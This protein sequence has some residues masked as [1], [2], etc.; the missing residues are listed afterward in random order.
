MPRNVTLG[1]L[2]QLVRSEAKHSLSPA[3][4]RAFEDHIKNSLRR[5]Q[6]RLWQDFKWPHLTV[7]KDKAINAGQRYYDLPP[8]IIL[9]SVKEVR[10]RH[11][12]QWLPEIPQGIVMEHYNSFDPTL[13]QRSD[14]VQRWDIAKNGL[15]QIELWPL[16]AS[17]GDT[18]RI[19]GVRNLNP[20]IAESDRCDLDSDMLVLFVA[21][22]LLVKSEPEL[23]KEK[24]GSAR[25][26]YTRLKGAQGKKATVSMVG[27]NGSS[28]RRAPTHVAVHKVG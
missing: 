20:L 17:N 15:E 26:L 14:P 3:Q 28:A 4:G 10:V 22:E 9:E 2:V 13:D 1:E 18:L 7:E 27:G 16:P 8:E 5:I 12:G 24:L 19:I 11:A 25:S 6:T 21:A 23:A